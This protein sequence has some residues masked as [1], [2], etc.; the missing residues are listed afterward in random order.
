MPTGKGDFPFKSAWFLR[1]RGRGLTPSVGEQVIPL[2][3]VGYVALS[4]FFFESGSAP[5]TITVYPNGAN[6]NPRFETVRGVWSDAR[7]LTATGAPTYPTSEVVL[8]GEFAGTYIISRIGFIFDTSAIPDTATITSATLYVKSTGGGD[9]SETTNP[10]NG[11]LVGYT[12]SSDTAPVAADFLQFNLTRL[13]DTDVTRAAFATGSSYKSWALNATGLAAISKTGNT[14]LGIRPSNDFSDATAPTARSYAQGFYAAQT[15][16][17]DDPYLEI[18]YVDAP[19]GSTGTLAVTTADD[20]LSASGSTTVIGTLSLTTAND[21]STASGSSTVVGTVDVTTADDTVVA[22]GNTGSVT[23]TIDVTTADDTLSASGTT[24]VTGAISLTT[25]NDTSTASG[26]TT[27]VGSLALT[28]NDDTSVASGNSGDV[29]GTINVTTADDTSSAIGSTAI[30]GNLS[31]TTNDDTSNASGFTTVV[32]NVNVTTNDDVL[33]ANG[34]AGA[35]TGTVNVTTGNDTLVAEG[36]TPQVANDLFGGVAH[37]KKLHERSQKVRELSVLEA[38]KPQEVIEIPQEIK[39]IISSV[40]KTNKKEAELQKQLK[41]QLKALEIQIRQEYI[42]ALKAE[43][44]RQYLIAEQ[45]RQ[46]EEEAIA[47]MM[48]ALI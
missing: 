37:F 14:K 48:I 46:E 18:T 27:V 15:G 13:A 10:A 44:I 23:G 3:Q 45:E 12:P 25:A 2:E 4:E 35:T 8:Q 39:E 21:T 38:I 47:M 40:V 31:V 36:N 22:S 43:A 11:A 19:S 28:T 29:S 24:T 9:G 1:G 5:T 34:T 16:T 20:T 41:A 33:T 32:G 26:S 6:G 42:D 30:V 7:G 17:A